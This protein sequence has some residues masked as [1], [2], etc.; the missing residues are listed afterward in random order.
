M[1]NRWVL[2]PI[3]ERELRLVARRD[4]TYWGRAGAAA[5][6]N[7]L[8]LTVMNFQLGF[9]GFL[10]A[11]V[12][13]WLVSSLALDWWVARRTRARL[14]RDLTLW[15]LRRGADEFEHYDGWRRLGRRL[16][17]WWARRSQ[18]AALKMTKTGKP[19]HPPS[20]HPLP[21]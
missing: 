11:A 10:M 8:L 2:P 5:V 21:H 12:P 14:H 15:A 20:G 18:A 19:P 6:G 9:H 4:R 17:R 1:T 7:T 13:S 16:G 3:I